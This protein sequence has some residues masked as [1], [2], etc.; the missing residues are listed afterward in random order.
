MTTL[1]VHAPCPWVTA[2][3]STNRHWR[4][5]HALTKAW[6]DAAHVYARH[7]LLQ[8]VTGPVHITG[9]IHRADRRIIDV[10]GAVPTLKACIDGLRDAG[11]L[12]GDDYRHVTAITSA[13]GAPDKTNPR[14][15]ITIT[16]GGCP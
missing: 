6:R 13:W 2:N 3:A 15:T 16:P 14:L 5:R 12:D 4:H 10:D 9:T 11:V 7:A 1:D 8:P